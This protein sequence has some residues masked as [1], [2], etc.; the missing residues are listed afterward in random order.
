MVTLSKT[1]Y[2]SITNHLL[3]SRTR[4]FRMHTT[5]MIFSD[6]VTGQ[7]MGWGGGVE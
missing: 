3:F 4:T 2:V 6:I 7:E 1:V 5:G